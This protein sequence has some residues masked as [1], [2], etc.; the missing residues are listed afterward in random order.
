MTTI[1]RDLLIGV[2]SGILSGAFVYWITKRREEK[3]QAYYY[4]L[5]FLFG[6]MRECKIYVPSE[7]LEKMSIVGQK[8][9]KWHDAIFALLDEMNPY[10]IEDR[11]LSEREE[12]ISTNMLDALDELSKW[13]KK[14]LL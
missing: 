7:Q 11:E 6:V 4:W 13:K 8:G 10:E 3:R 1:G 5:N 12:R 2:L 9:S 14:N